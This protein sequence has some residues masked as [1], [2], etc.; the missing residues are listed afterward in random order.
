MPC[1]VTFCTD[2]NEGSGKLE[3][4]MA[5]RFWEAALLVLAAAVILANPARASQWQGSFDPVGF[6]IDNISQFSGTGLFQLDDNCLLAD[7]TY[8]AAACHVVLLGQTL[9]LTN[10]SNQTTHIVY[11]FPVIPD[12]V[13]IIDIVIGGGALVGVD[14]N[15]I[16]P[17]FASDASP[18]WVE[19]V[20]DPVN[21]YTGTCF[22]GC[23]P[24]TG[25]FLTANNVTFVR[26]S[27]PEP[28]TLGLIF[29][30]LGAGWMARRRRKHA[31]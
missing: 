14:T 25:Q 23:F 20:S 1:S 10:T 2:S 24:N 31:A 17:G 21:I 9:D 22:E 18:W 7:G 26:L 8:S 28:G 6:T 12:T 3:R 19:W 11:G 4:H 15:L 30:A 16:G 13:D 29:S 5:R 27:A